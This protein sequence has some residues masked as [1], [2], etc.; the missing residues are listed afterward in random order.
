MH[1]HNLLFESIRKVGFDPKNIKTVFITHG[2]VDHCGGVRILQEYS[3]CEV[4][5]PMGD[6]FF[7]DKRRDLI[8][9]RMLFDA[10]PVDFGGLRPGRILTDAFF[11]GF[12]FRHWDTSARICRDMLRIPR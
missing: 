12:T 10:L 1:V 7:L 5:F 4:W 2:H 3:G 6:A 9:E 8:L 11:Y